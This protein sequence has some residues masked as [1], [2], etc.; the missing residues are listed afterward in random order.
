MPRSRSHS[1]LKTILV[2]ASCVYLALSF[3]FGDFDPHKWP[4]MAAATS[5]SALTVENAGKILQAA[6]GGTGGTGTPETLI[7]VYG[8]SGCVNEVS[9]IDWGTLNPGQSRQHSFY[10][11]NVGAVPV[12]LALSAR[13]WNPASAEQYMSLTWNYGNQTM[14]ANDVFGVTLTLTVSPS[15]TS[16]TD[17]SFEIVVTATS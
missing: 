16:I 6:G 3:Y 5:F 12:T 8:E 7:K 9:S 11:K 13:N 15:I 2:L 14:Q 10:L 4:L 1:N 17:F